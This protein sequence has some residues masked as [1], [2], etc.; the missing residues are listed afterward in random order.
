LKGAQKLDDRLSKFG[1]EMPVTFAGK[2]RFA[3]FNAFTG[4]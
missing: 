2:M 4:Y 1:F 3:F